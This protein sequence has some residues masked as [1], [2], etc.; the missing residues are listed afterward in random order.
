M[1]LAWG[2]SSGMD[3][4]ATAGGSLPGGNG[5]KTELHFLRKG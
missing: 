3:C 1:D 5:V 2:S 4:H